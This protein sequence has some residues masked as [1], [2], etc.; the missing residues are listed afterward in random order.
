M[1]S[2]TICAATIASR[3]GPVLLGITPPPLPPLPTLSELTVT[4]PLVV[5]YMMVVLWGLSDA[6]LLPA[7][8]ACGCMPIVSRL[9]AT[10][11]AALTFC[12]VVESGPAP[13]N[14]SSPKRWDPPSLCTHFGR[15]CSLIKLGNATAEYQ[16]N[17]YHG[18]SNRENS[19]GCRT[20]EIKN[21]RVPKLWP[22]I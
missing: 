19:P 9:P 3:T 6:P 15:A 2:R 1:W 18:Q 13:T 22:K 4:S 12:F 11:P 7:S 8:F 10:L 21:L 17:H 14:C 16:V 20:A 5:A